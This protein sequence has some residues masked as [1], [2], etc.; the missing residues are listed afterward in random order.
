MTLKIKYFKVNSII[1]II[2]LL[3]FSKKIIILL[4]QFD[5]LIVCYLTLTQIKINK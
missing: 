1:F 3:S 2:I 4:F 5:Y